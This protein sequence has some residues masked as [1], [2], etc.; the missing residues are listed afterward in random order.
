METVLSPAPYHLLSYG[1]LLGTQLYQVR[2]PI[3]ISL[4]F[5]SYTYEKETITDAL[6][7]EF[8][9]DQ[10]HLP[11]PA[12]SPVRNSPATSLP[13]VFQITSRPATPR[14]FDTPADRPGVVE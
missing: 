8:R 9:N 13:L 4:L 2:I 3:Q 5:T 6:T 7:L 12:K 1:T 10:T 11:S 14:G